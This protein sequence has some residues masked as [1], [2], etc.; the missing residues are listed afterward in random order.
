[1]VAAVPTTDPEA[2]PHVWSCR[3]ESRDD[4][5]VASE[6]GVLVPPLDSESL[7]AAICHLLEKPELRQSMAR[8]GKEVVA[9]SFSVEA[10]VAGNLD[11]Y[12]CLLAASGPHDRS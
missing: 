6:N 7:S 12:H 2:T 11:V 4:K 8:K 9:Q 10:M 5:L 3:L 1:M